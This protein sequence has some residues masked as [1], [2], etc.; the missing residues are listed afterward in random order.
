MKLL[1]DSCVSA[2]TGEKL[3]AAG[4]DVVWVGNWP[5]DPGDAAILARARAE[6][7]VLLTLDK[8]FGELAIVHGEPHCGIVRLVNCSV[9]RQADICESLLTRHGKLLIEGG[10][11]TV[12]PGRL[13]IRPAAADE[14]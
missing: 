3:R 13:R 8:D 12:E 6:R 2:K 9:T 1:L 5:A 11:V 10:I 4:H 7:R 14:F